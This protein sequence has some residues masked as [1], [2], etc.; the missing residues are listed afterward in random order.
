MTTWI[1]GVSGDGGNTSTRATETV[2]VTPRVSESYPKAHFGECF[3]ES[4]LTRRRP[5]VISIERRNAFDDGQ[6]EILSASLP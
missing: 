4:T 5:T 1:S 2:G 6:T 3:A